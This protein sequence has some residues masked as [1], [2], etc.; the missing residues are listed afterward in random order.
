MLLVNIRLR[1]YG[2][3]PL[4]HGVNCDVV[5]HYEGESPIEENIV[6]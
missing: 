5:M 4:R 2:E 3:V 1:V 6:D